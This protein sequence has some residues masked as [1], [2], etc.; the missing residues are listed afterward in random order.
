MICYSAI[1]NYMLIVA[2]FITHTHKNAKINSYYFQW[3]IDVQKK[4]GWL[5]NNRDD[6]LNV[7]VCSTIYVLKY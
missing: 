1:D 3:K 2:L 7:C 4:M 5:I 6:G